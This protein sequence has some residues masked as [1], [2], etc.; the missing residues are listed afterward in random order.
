MAHE[1]HEW[2]A[3]R[4][5]LE[6]RALAGPTY[7]EEKVRE[8]IESEDQLCYDVASNFGQDFE[9]VKH[10]AWFKHA[11]AE[12]LLVISITGKRSDG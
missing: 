1:N 9:N 3:K 6:V 11:L 8:L 10:M 12:E 7:Y 2:E 4:E 5:A